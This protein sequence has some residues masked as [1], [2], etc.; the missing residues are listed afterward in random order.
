M[1]NY[2]KIQQVSIH[3]YYINWQMLLQVQWTSDSDKEQVLRS[4]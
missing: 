4:G 3:H 2:N 1:T